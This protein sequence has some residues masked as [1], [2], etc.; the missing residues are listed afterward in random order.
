M[1]YAPAAQAMEGHAKVF[2][3]RLA[4][5]IMLNDL[6]SR[7]TR[8]SYGLCKHRRDYG[9][10]HVL[11]AGARRRTPADVL[12]ILLCGRPNA[13]LQFGTNDDGSHSHAGPPPDSGGQ[14]AYLLC[15]FSILQP[16]CECTACKCVLPPPSECRRQQPA[17]PADT[18]ASGGQAMLT[19]GL[20][21][22][23]QPAARCWSS[24]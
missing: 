16:P 11:V 9:L 2:L 13:S 19:L 7:I 14:R 21:S 4:C 1:S 3:L 24:S 6:L 23:V 12:T 20:C 18:Y 15:A 22:R 17:S 5:A 8:S 10:L